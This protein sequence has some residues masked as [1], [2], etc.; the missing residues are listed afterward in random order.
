MILGVSGVMDDDVHHFIDSGANLVLC[1][2][3]SLAGLW[4]ALRGTD[5]F[6]SE[7]VSKSIQHDNS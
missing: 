2:P 1:K 6:N 3:I 7:V 5:F 4:K